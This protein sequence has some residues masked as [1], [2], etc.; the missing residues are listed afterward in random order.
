MTMNVAIIEIE[1]KI[2]NF[3]FRLQK[4]FLST[5]HQLTSNNHSVCNGK[6]PAS[7]LNLCH[8]QS[9]TVLLLYL[10]CKEQIVDHFS[11]CNL[12]VFRTA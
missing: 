1:I 4:N 3:G 7:I 2:P 5:P 9:T 10:H 12:G 11:V 8:L 6:I